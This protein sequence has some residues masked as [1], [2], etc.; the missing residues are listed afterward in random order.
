MKEVK[1]MTDLRSTRRQVLKRAG[2][3]GAT[4]AFLSPTTA[5]AKQNDAAQGPE[6]SWIGTVTITSGPAFPLFQALYTYAAGGGLVETDQ[7]SFN[8][9]SP[10][11]PR[12]GVWV[13]TREDAFASTYIN[14]TFDSQGKPTGTIKIRETAV[15]SERGN[16]YTGSGK[17]DVL[18]LNGNVI[19]SGTFTSQATRIRV[20][21]V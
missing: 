14:L 21:P 20:E 3:L 9:Q 8:P 6:G 16:A 19:A 1:N 15:L 17:F 13:S 2:I 4:A 7:I 5:L 10:D 18:D 11:S 12:H